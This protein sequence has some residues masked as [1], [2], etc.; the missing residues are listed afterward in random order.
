MWWGEG[1]EMD[2]YNLWFNI[3]PFTTAMSIMDYKN[4]TKLQH[5]NETGTVISLI[6]MYI[7]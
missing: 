6:H 4:L 3:P 2:S 5:E 7:I 1:R